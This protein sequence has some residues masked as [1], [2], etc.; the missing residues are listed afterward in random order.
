M[1]YQIFIS[2]R[3]DGGDVTAKLICESLKNSGYTVFYDYDAIKG[4]R[5]DSRIYDAI[6][7]CDDFISVLTPNALTRCKN[8]DD[9]V[10]NE[11]RYALEK[12]K[13]IIPVMVKDFEFPQ[14]LPEDIQNISQY[15]GVRFSMDYFEATMTK[16]AEMLSLSTKLSLQHV[17]LTHD[18]SASQQCTSSESTT[19]NE[20]A[21]E[22]SKGAIWIFIV[23]LVFFASF[24]SLF[25]FSVHDEQK[26]VEFSGI[27]FLFDKNSTVSV[28]VAEENA[29]VNVALQEKYSGNI[30]EY[31]VYHVE[32]TGN[33]SGTLTCRL[34]LPDEF[35]RSNTDL[36][37][38]ENDGELTKV[39]YWDRLWAYSIFRR[40][41]VGLRVKKVT[42]TFVLVNRP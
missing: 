41:Y 36:Y 3:R 28:E 27:P 4:G 37:I 18:E 5:F 29:I 15:N 24:L 10:R 7:Q 39:G 35:K 23:A 14:E 2:Y 9:W 13:N 17:N 38:I 6:D 30:P 12:G 32:I 16:I 25:Y 8:E 19:A 33:N 42:G 21:A 26:L 11:I 31:V 20:A 1:K 34:K 22:H 40:E